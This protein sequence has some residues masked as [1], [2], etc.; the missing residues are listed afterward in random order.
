LIGAG[1][2]VTIVQAV[3]GRDY[4]GGDFQSPVVMI[5]SN[6]VL[7][8][9]TIS[10][11]TFQGHIPEANPGNPTGVFE[12][13]GNTGLNGL[14]THG[15]LSFDM[16]DRSIWPPPERYNITITNNKFIYCGGIDLYNVNGFEIS[17]N[18]MVRESHQIPYYVG[19][20]RY[21]DKANGGKIAYL[22]NCKDG[23]IENNVGYSPKDTGVISI[24]GGSNIDVVCN[25]I[26][27]AELLPGD[28]EFSC[29]GIRVWNKSTD[30]EVSEN[31]IKGFIDDPGDTNYYGTAVLIEN[32]TC[33]VTR[34]ILED[35]DYGVLVKKISGEQ[36]VALTG[37]TISGCATGVL[38]AETCAETGPQISGN[39][40]AENAVHV[41]DDRSIAPTNYLEE[42]LQ[43]NT[44]PEGSQVDGNKIMVSEEGETEVLFNNTMLKNN[45]GM[46]QESEGDAGEETLEELDLTPLENAIQAAIA[47]KEGVAVSE[48]GQDVPAG[49]Y[50]VTQADMDVLDAAIAAAEVA[51]KT[52][53]TQQG[54]AEAVEAL[55]AAVSTFN[56]AKQEVID[57]EEIGVPGEGEESVQ[58]EEPAEDEKSVEDEEAVEGEEQEE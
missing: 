57:E 22:S 14:S 11:F 19:D 27:A 23:V 3:Q 20:D 39:T 43:N 56:D 42:L 2:D 4:N 48:D 50:W 41:Q 25:C 51:K 12:G 5:T 32:S 29:A 35:S 21:H 46:E 18:I 31:T 36:Y 38:L 7:D 10:G 33:E 37:N 24:A 49:T 8:G 30:I 54:V 34:N 17:N 52:A 13:W 16:N 58:A 6:D 55:E 1:R 53:E 15:V 9:I 28:T 44:F 45:Q 40:F 26:M 47:A